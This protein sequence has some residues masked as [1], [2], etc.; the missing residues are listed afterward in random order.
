[1]SVPVNNATQIP[2]AWGYVLCDDSFLGGWGEAEGK[3]NICIFPVK[4]AQ[5][6]LT[7]YTNAL[8]RP[9][10][11]NVRLVNNKPKSPTPTQLY[12]LFSQD[13]AQRWY[14]PGGFEEVA[15]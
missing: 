7:V 1:M 12:S 9:E 13:T 10:M 14:T 11:R 8:H 5:E 4:D 15:G 3:T 2:D 6:G